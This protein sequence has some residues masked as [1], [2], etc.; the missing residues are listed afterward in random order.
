MLHV[1]FQDVNTVAIRG[2]ACST[3]TDHILGTSGSAISDCS[4]GGAYRILCVRLP[5]MICSRLRPLRSKP[6][7]RYGWV[8]SPY[9]TGTCTRQEPPSLTRRDNVRRSPRPAAVPAARGLQQ[10]IG[11]APWLAAGAGV[12]DPT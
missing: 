1:G 5:C 10:G 6:N 3:L 12:A 8:A 11:L 7:T 4:D 2:L 9:P